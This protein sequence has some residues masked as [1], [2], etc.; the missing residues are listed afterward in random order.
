MLGPNQSQHGSQGGIFMLDK[1]DSVMRQIG[2][3][4]GSLLAGGAIYGAGP[5]AI[6]D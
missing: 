6:L 5:L 3:W 4:V 1:F 2:F